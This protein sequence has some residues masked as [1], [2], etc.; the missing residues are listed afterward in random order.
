MDRL[1]GVYAKW[2]RSFFDGLVPGFGNGG[3]LVTW[4]EMWF[5]YT[6]LG[7]RCLSQGGRGQDRHFAQLNSDRRNRTLDQNGEKEIRRAVVRGETGSFLSR[8]LYR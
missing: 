3:S 4:S 7:R 1:I 2:T 5:S 8:L 6:S